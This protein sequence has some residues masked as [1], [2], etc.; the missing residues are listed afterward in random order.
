MGSLV[1]RSIVSH[2]FCLP[3]VFDDYFAVE[4]K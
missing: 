4:E 1:K 2:T 3:F